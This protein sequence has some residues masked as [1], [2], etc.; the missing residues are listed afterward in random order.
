MENERNNNGVLIGLLLGVIISLL[1]VLVLFVSGTISLKSN[2]NSN[3]TTSENTKVDTN[4]SD[5]VIDSNDTSTKDY[6]SFIG[7]WTNNETN[8]TI[9]IKNITSNKITFTWFLYRLAGIDDDTTISFKDGK[10]VFYY[11]GYDDKNYDGKQT[12]DEKFMRKATIEL[13]SDGVNVIIEDVKSIDTSYDVLN[14]FSG[15][16]YVKSG[17]YTHQNRTN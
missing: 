6:S 8:N 15:S 14:N 10:A 7:T 11:Q 17:T 4:T 12:E 2:T 3:N 13:A 16:V 5:N 9:T 1:I